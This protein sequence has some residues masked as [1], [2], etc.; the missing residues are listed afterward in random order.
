M[1]GEKYVFIDR[2]GVINRDGEGRTEHGYITEWE[3][4]EFLPGVLDALRELTEAGYEN[5]VISNQKCVGRGLLSS[6]GLEALTGKM[7]E[8]VLEAGGRI[9]RVY[10]CPHLDED[11]CDCRKPKA[12]LFKKAKEE[13]GISSFE[14][15][16]FIGDSQRDMQAARRAGL[17]RILV[18]SGKSS[19]R[20]A[21]RW[22]YEPD[23]ICRDLLEAA[24]YIIRK[25]REEQDAR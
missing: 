7:L 9:R 18:L 6:D 17:G 1:M 22:E 20:D 14:G 10:Y 15:R 19:R 5:V 4:F 12:G 16:F 13:L 23:H 2:D 3:D 25:D 11:D 24:R 21:E 8:A